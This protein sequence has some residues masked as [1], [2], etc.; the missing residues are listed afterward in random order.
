ML[1]LRWQLGEKKRRKKN[2][3]AFFWFSLVILN[4]LQNFSFKYRE[5]LQ[6]TIVLQRTIS[7]YFPIFKY[8]SSQR[9]RGIRQ[10]L[11][12]QKK[13]DLCCSKVLQNLN[14]IWPIA[15]DQFAFLRFICRSSRPVF[16][17]ISQNSQENP[18]GRE[19]FL[20]KLQA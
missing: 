4:A 6:S 7:S 11:Q 20:I 16:L 19:S 5:R 9:N 18:C 1:F 3:R 8:D 12:H 14:L 2:F 17:E 15:W 10:K 13:I